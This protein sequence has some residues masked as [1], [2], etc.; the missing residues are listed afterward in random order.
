MRGLPT[1]CTFISWVVCV[2]SFL[3]SCEY[4]PNCKL[5]VTTTD[6][7]F[8]LPLLLLTLGPWLM[9]I[10]LVYALF[11]T[12]KIELSNSPN[13]EFNVL[14]NAFKIKKRDLKKFLK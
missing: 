5:T 8:Y 4:T 3:S 2:Y 6:A 1:V 13:L 14:Q 7:S 12:S 10:S 9:R 11:V